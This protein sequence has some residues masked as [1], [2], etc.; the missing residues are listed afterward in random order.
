[1]CGRSPRSRKF[2]ARMTRAVFA[3]IY[4][5]TAQG[6]FDG[7]NILNRLDEIE[8]RDEATERRL[9]EMRKKLL[10]R[11]GSRVR[12]GFDDKVL[13]DWNGLMIAALAK[14][15]EAFDKPQWLAAA[16]AAFN[17]VSTKMIANGRLLHAYRAGEAKAPATA[18]D[19]ANMI[20]AAL[21]L[22]NVT[23]KRAIRRVGAGVDRH[24][25]QALL[26]G[27]HRRL[28]FR[29]RRHLGSHRAADERTGRGD[30]ERERHDGLESHG[31]LLSG[32]ETS[33]IE[34][35]PTRCCE[36]SPGRCGRTCW[37][38]PACSPPRST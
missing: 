8:L 14:A 20:R 23:G 24:S 3:E 30:A 13:A 19:Y 9:A 29:G 11:R 4:D 6:N 5:V 32:P 16:E 10:A 25:R 1:M 15:A 34:S 28:L 33:A 26:G 22:A 17:F 38:M 37:R 21:A 12:P 18:N 27:R 31:A 7:H 35:A 36:P 2:S